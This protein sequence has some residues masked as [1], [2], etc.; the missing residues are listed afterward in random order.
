M[1]LG[2]MVTAS[3]SLQ[4]VT[5]IPKLEYYIPS[6]SEYLVKEIVTFFNDLRCALGGCVQKETEW[7]EEV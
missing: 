5:W 6:L 7:Y 1:Y 4:I 2:E 3:L